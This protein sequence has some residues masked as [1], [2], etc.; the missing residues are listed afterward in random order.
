[1]LSHL[2]APAETSTH[3]RERERE[4]ERSKHEILNFFGAFTRGEET[5]KLW[6]V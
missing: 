3:T 5:N 6:A 4:K 1:M 2:A